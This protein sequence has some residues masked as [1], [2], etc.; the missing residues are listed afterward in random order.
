MEQGI[1]AFLASR[2]RAFLFALSL[3]LIGLIGL[4]DYVTGYDLSLS[5]FYLAP[6]AIIAWY[7]TTVTGYLTSALSALVWLL[8]NSLAVAPGRLTP[9]LAAWNTAVRLGFFVIVA[10]L[11]TSLR[12]AHETQRELA[13]TDS[14]TGVY[15]G[16]T[17]RELVQ[18]E[19]MRAH[20]M[21]YPLSLIYID[22]DNFKALNDRHGHSQGD[23]LLQT[24]GRG[25]VESLRGTDVI[26]RLG[27]DEFAVLLPNTD[28]EQ[29][30]LVAKKL[31]IQLN[32]STKAVDP[33]VSLSMGVITNHSRTPEAEALISAADELMYEAKRGGK[34]V[35]CR[36]VFRPES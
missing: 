24:V 4:L 18:L 25:L 5:L 34:N 22:L 23:A 35:I 19:L 14:L 30:G 9:P 36:G 28:Q 7:D 33:L 31:H 6:V 26:G 13:R 10:K 15:N 2:S 3:V 12:L 32:A 17:F 27:G 29:A 1:D 20:R 11:L 16:R 21:G 8:A